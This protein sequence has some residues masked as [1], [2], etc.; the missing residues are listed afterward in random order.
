MKI[1]I[2]RD[3]EVNLE[4]QAYQNLNN[5][6]EPIG[7]KCSFNTQELK[8][9][10]STLQLQKTPD[11]EETTHEMLINMGSQAKKEIITAYT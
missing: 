6:T 4:L 1:P 9:A 3:Q 11:P 8:T 10:L 2:E 5:A 7:M